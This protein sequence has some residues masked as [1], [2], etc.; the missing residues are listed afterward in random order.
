[1]LAKAGIQLQEN[2]EVLPEYFVYRIVMPPQTMFRGILDLSPGARLDVA[3]E[4]TGCKIVTMHDYDP[5]VPKLNLSVE[6]AAERALTLLRKSLQPLSGIAGRTAVL[7]SGGI[8]SSTLYNEVTR[9]V[10]PVMCYSTDYPFDDPTLSKERGYALSAAAALKAPHR[11]FEMSVS[12][13]L[14]RLIWAVAAAEI[15]VHHLQSVCLDAL[16]SGGMLRDHD[17]VLVGVGAGGSYG[18]FRNFL[19]RKDQ[20]SFSVARREPVRSLLRLISPVVSKGRGILKAIDDAAR[21]GISASPEDPLWE[22]HAYGDPAWVCEYL[23]VTA[24]EVVRWPRRAL[25]K[26]SS[27]P[28]E[29]RWALYSL[30]G[31]EALTQSIWSKIGEV[32]GR[33]ISFPYYDDSLL[34]FLFS[35]SW[36]TKLPRPRRALRREMARQAGVPAFIR[37]R[38]KSGFGVARRGWAER[39]DVFDPVVP[40]AAKA[41]GEAPLRQLQSSEGKRP[42]LFW[43]L[44]NYGLWRR[45]CIDR[46]DPSR[47]LKELEI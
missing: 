12:T 1:M 6:E 21:A 25:E 20:F 11:H 46:E 7:L 26:F 42:M 32:N 36:K 4:A 3:V 31:D 43:N 17:V 16:F 15:P 47:L 33:R 40:L 5:P 39:G 41:L 38:P 45:M 14:H 30:L 23:G 8:D 24:D 2:R 37:N 28:L 27:R 13:Y 10:G 35:V 34:E 22:W 9:T 29:D 19:N 44:L 18:N